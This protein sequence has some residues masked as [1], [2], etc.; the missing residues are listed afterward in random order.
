M[1]SIEEEGELDSQGVPYPRSPQVDMEHLDIQQPRVGRRRSEELDTSS[2]E[3]QFTME[4]LSSG[5]SDEAVIAPEP[6][7]QC[8]FCLFDVVHFDT[9]CANN[10]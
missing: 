2:E 9:D 1:K 5:I 4:D 10:Q 6:G 8:M 3:L 7:K